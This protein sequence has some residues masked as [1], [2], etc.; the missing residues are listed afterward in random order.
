MDDRI[1]ELEK[2]LFK[3]EYM[4]NRKY[5][6]DIIDDKYEE[7]GK[8]GKRIT[9][10]NVIEELINFR[11]DRNITIYNYSCEEICQNVW[12]IH[13][14]TLNNKTKFYRTSIWKKS[15]D[16]IKIIFHQASEYKEEVNLIAS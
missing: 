12:L 3:Y 9:K 8:S 4:S 5:L 7:I 10:N 6:N 1:L 11:E 16:H 2:S 13:Y 14:I 15:S